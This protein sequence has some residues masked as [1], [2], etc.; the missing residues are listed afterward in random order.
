MLH[1][2]VFFVVLIMAASLCFI[3]WDSHPEEQLRQT[4][5]ERVYRAGTVIFHP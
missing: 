4:Q 3:L 5:Q 1:L 2:H